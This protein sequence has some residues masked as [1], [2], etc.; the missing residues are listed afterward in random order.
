VVVVVVV[1]EV[2]VPDPTGL[3]V[4]FCGAA[5]AERGGWVVVDA[6]TGGNVVVGAPVVGVVPAAWGPVPPPVWDCVPGVCEPLGR[7]EDVEEDAIPDDGIMGTPEGTAVSPNGLNGVVYPLAMAD[8]AL[9][10]D[11][12]PSATDTTMATMPRTEAP[13]IA[14]CRRRTF[15]GRLSPIAFLITTGMK[16]PP[17]HPTLPGTC[18]REQQPPRRL[19][20]GYWLRKGASERGPTGDM[21]P[22]GGPFTDG[23]R[24]PH[25]GRGL[26]QR[27]PLQ[28]DLPGPRHTTLWRRRVDEPP[29]DTA[30]LS[31]LTRRSTWPPGGG[32]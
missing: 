25:S 23:T 9:G 32:R 13:P 8:G 10:G 26:E 19:P 24:R 3:L 1:V 18:V 17:P 27:S 7:E 21:F 11:P 16:R 14:F 6:V 28:R 22:T 29:S 15:I 4:V 30:A 5:A 31:A 12:G 20:S 2:V